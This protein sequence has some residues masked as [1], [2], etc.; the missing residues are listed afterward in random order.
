MVDIISGVSGN[1]SFLSILRQ[2]F[3]DPE[4]IVDSTPNRKNS[5]QKLAYV[6]KIADIVARDIT[7]NFRDNHFD[8]NPPNKYCELMR[9]VSLEVYS[10]YLFTINNNVEIIFK[11]VKK[12]DVDCYTIVDAFKGVIMSMLKDK[13]NFHWGRVSMI[14]TLAAVM[15]HTCRKKNQDYTE[16]FIKQIGEIFQEEKLDEWIL[17]NGGWVR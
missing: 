14:F 15:A 1:I 4:I 3:V 12:Q 9:K 11:E 17:E 2:V 7:S 10:K 5:K 16:N 8:C 13:T 6:R